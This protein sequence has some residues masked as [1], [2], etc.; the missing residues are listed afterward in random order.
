MTFKKSELLYIILQR[1]RQQVARCQ[2]SAPGIPATPTIIRLAPCFRLLQES[3]LRLRPARR[4]GPTGS[5]A[6]AG[7]WRRE[8]ADLARLQG[9]RP[10]P[11]RDP[12]NPNDHS[13][14]SVFS[15]AFV[16][17]PWIQEKNSDK[18]EEDGMTGSN[19]KCFRQ[20]GQ[21]RGNA[22]EAAHSPGSEEDDEDGEEGEVQDEQSRENGKVAPSSPSSVV[23]D[24]NNQDREQT[25]AEL[26][27]VQ[28]NL[29]ETRTRQRK[30]YLS[31]AITAS[32]VFSY[33][34]GQGRHQEAAEPPPK[35][36]AGRKIPRPPIF[37]DRPF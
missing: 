15:S 17:L 8:L 10:V 26:G 14:G 31:P 6:T 3:D 32:S 28:G 1:S 29:E 18:K 4:P 33:S 5:S 20:P 12:S 13:F 34:K 36:Q 16:Q 7:T 37:P 19:D 25:I 9:A 11:T 24:S 23:S 22:E 35:A 30:W 2:T 27:Q 21:E